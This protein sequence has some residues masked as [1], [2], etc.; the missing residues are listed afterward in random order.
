MPAPI[1]SKIHEL[2]G[3]YI[4]DPQRSRNGEPRTKA[5]IGQYSAINDTPEKCWDELVDLV[6]PGV[7][8]DADRI[9]LERAAKL[10]AQSRKLGDDFPPTN[11]KILQSYLSKMGLN[12]SDR[13]KLTVNNDGPKDPADKYF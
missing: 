2:R 3:S 6:C 11:D 13:A 5:G 4:K 10:L 12:P 1:P 8:G 7:L 9:W